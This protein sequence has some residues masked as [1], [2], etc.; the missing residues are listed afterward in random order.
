MTCLHCRGKMV[1]GEAPFQVDRK[2]SHLILDRV[3]AWV[4]QQ[5][6]EA[7]FE[8][9]EVDWIQDAVRKLDQHTHHLAASA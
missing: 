6:G 7:Y 2:G 5:C 3:P 9:K 8:P 1:R 4:C